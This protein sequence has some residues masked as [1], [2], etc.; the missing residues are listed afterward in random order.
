M[1]KLRVNSPATILEWYL[2]RASEQ[3]VDALY[4]LLCVPEV[5]RY[6]SDGVPPPRKQAEKWIELNCADYAAGG[7][8]LW[9]LE[10]D[11]QRLAGCV[12]LEAD[13]RPRTGEI[14]Y[15]LHPEYWGQGLATR[16]SWTVVERVFRERLLDQIV[17]GADGPNQAS[18][19]VMSRLGMKYLRAVRYPL[20]PGVE[21]ALR[22]DDPKA[23]P[24][25]DRLPRHD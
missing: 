8:G 4:A 9:M 2:R 12:C 21:Y 1:G 24:L 7:L 23:T 10:A 25:P 5:Y 3:D 16:M 20:G 14:I 17:A 6:L 19:A 15:L 11:A 13:S 18:V 22:H